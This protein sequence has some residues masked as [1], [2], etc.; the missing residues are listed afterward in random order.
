MNWF[1]PTGHDNST[2]KEEIKILL[3]R[4]L[5]HYVPELEWIKDFL[6]KHI[7]HELSHLTSQR[8]D[9]LSYHLLYVMS[10]LFNHYFIYCHTKF[11]S[12][13]PKVCKSPDH[14]LLSHYVKLVFNYK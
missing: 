5:W 2:L 9:V 12:G 13:N 6:V 8:S 3:A 14:C 4:D 11:P 10:W 1:I 7:E